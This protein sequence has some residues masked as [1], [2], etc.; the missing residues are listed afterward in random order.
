MDASIADILSCIISSD[1]M[2]LLLPKPSQLIWIVKKNISFS[3]LDESFQKVFS[4]LGKD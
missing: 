3:S 1:D 2:L 4:A